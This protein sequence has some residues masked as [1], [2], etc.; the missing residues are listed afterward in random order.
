MAAVVFPHT[1]SVLVC[2]HAKDNNPRYS[3]FLTT[4][5]LPAKRRL[6]AVVEAQGATTVPV[7]CPGWDR[8]A[9]D[10]GQDRRSNLCL[11]W[12]TDR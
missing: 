5:D 8:K 11:L 6:V 7:L 3:D 4:V 12:I 1:G 2:L 10:P 9:V